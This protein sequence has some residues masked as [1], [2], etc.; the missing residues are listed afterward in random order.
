[1]LQLDEERIHM[2]NLVNSRFNYLL[3]ILAIIITGVLNS[4]SLL[5]ASRLFLFGS[6]ISFGLVW[7]IIRAQSRFDALLNKIHKD[8][9]HAATFAKKI[10]EQSWWINLPARHSARWLIGYC[11][12][13]LLL[14]FMTIGIF[15]P[16]I[17]YVETDKKNIIAELKSENKM[18]DKKLLKIE[19]STIEQI[20][21][22][23]MFNER[24]LKIEQIVTNKIKTLSNKANSAAEKQVTD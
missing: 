1:M 3:V 18:L 24:L 20:V 6:I 17:I 22:N 2:E 5:Q 11:F 15:Y 7:T 9:N 14:T 10:A 16:K 19:Q 21:T 13:C 12:P 4:N 23:K 8:Q